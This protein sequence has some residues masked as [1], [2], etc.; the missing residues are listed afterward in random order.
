MLVEPMD[1]VTIGAGSSSGLG[2]TEGGKEE[3]KVY[4]ITVCISSID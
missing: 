2:S 1:E 4:I 3:S